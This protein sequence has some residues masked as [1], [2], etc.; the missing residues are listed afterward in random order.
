MKFSYE[1]WLRGHQIT[2]CR[3]GHA[4]VVT[5]VIVNVESCA[6]LPERKLTVTVFL[7]ET[8]ADGKFYF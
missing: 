6:L 2:G 1:D 5:L 8:D 7:Q 4:P 3:S